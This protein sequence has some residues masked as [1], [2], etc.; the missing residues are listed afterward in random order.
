MTKRIQLSAALPE[1]YKSI[2]HLHTVDLYTELERAA[3]ALTDAMTRLPQ[4]QDVPDDVY[5]QATSVFTEDQYVAVAWVAT[6]IN[7][8][9][10]LG[11]TSH[12]PLPADPK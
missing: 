9:N 11:V 3:L 2:L 6:V 8:F 12:K 1:A 7:A 5:Q 4:N 10:R